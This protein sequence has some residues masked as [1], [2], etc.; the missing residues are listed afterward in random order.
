MSDCDTYQISGKRTHGDRVAADFADLPDEE[1]REI[2]LQLRQVTLDH[3]P[4]DDR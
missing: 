1:L 4:A 3:L 2:A